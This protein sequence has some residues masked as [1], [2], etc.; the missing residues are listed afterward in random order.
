MRDAV[1]RLMGVE[2]MCLLGG[3]ASSDIMKARV[4]QWAKWEVCA[5]REVVRM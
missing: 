5:S 1:E 3:G 4:E 2:E